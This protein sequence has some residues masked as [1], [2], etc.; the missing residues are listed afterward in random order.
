MQKQGFSKSKNDISI[1]RTEIK[2]L[3]DYVREMG[4]KLDLNSSQYEELKEGLQEMMTKIIEDYKIESA[5]NLREVVKKINENV[6][7]ESL[8]H[9]SQQYVPIDFIDEVGQQIVEL[10]DRITLIQTRN[11][12]SRSRIQEDPVVLAE[13]VDL[14]LK[15]IERE[16]EAINKKTADSSIKAKDIDLSIEALQKKNEDY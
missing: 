10:Q 5:K 12:G 15:K 3:K 11:D 8:S 6:R 4:E 2:S 13:T 16:M 7:K 1:I 14:R 9:L